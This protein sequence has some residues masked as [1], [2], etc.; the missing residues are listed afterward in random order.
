MF[1]ITTLIHRM[2]VLLLC[3]S[4]KLDVIVKILNLG[5]YLR[6]LKSYSMQTSQYF[7]LI[8][9]PAPSISIYHPV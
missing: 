4:L 7:F 1:L 9:E 3:M 5:Y 2:I 6:H 8:S